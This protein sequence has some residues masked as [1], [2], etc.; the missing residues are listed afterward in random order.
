M[1]RRGGGDQRR[2]V[3]A[4]LRIRRSMRIANDRVRERLGNMIRSATFQ[5]YLQEPLS[6]SAT[7]AS[8]C[9]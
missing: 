1:Y 5:K 9:L 8:C 4:L 7:A 6:P 3:P 2:G